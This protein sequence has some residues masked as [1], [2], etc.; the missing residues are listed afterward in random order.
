MNQV[1]R[2]LG[3]LQDLHSGTPQFRVVNGENYCVYPS[4]LIYRAKDGMLM[5]MCL[6]GSLAECKPKLPDEFP[7]YLDV[8]DANVIG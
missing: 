3:F 7:E 6:D 2:I 8:L 5:E 4:G 1:D